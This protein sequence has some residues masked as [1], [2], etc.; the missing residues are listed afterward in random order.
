MHRV[1]AKAP[2]KIN[3][4]TQRRSHNGQIAHIIYTHERLSFENL[5]YEFV[6]EQC[7]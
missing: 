2:H 6:V 1:N 5:A 7:H 4:H 3:Q